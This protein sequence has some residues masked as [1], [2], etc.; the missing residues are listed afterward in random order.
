MCVCLRGNG[1]KY[2]DW[3]GDENL[4]V[5][6]RN[7]PPNK[8]DVWSDIEIVQWDEPRTT[9]ATLGKFLSPSFYTISQPSLIADK[10]M[11]L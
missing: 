7:L 4:S 2:K 5:R 11:A 6:P 3:G 10:M 8:S 9:T 1:V